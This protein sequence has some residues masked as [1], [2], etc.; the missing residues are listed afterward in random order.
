MGFSAFHGR[1]KENNSALDY[2]NRTRLGVDAHTQIGP[3]T[4]LGEISAGQD[5]STDRY[6]IL[7]EVDIH[8]NTEK[9][10]AFFQFIN[11]SKRLKNQRWDRLIQTNLGFSYTPD[12]YWTIS[13]QWT[14]DI[15]AFKAD[16]RAS[17]LKLQLRYRL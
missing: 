11:T 1:L 8:D 13:S 2:V 3:L 15:E 14:H 10:L 12:R 9:I 16:K 7:L 4:F 6:N 5:N 17:I